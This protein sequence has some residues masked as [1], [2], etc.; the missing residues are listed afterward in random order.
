[1]DNT[2]NENDQNRRFTAKIMH[3]YR[4]GEK[5][6]K[7]LDELQRET[8]DPNGCIDLSKPDDPARS[9]HPWDILGNRLRQDGRYKDAEHLYLL[10]ISLMEKRAAGEGGGKP[11]L[12][13]LAHNDLGVVYAQQGHYFLA[14][15]EFFLAVRCDVESSGAEGLKAPAARN[16]GL[17]LDNFASAER[18]RRRRRLAALLA[19]K[20]KWARAA[21]QKPQ[22]KTGAERTSDPRKVEADTDRPASTGNATIQRILVSTL[23]VLVVFGAFLGVTATTL[24]VCGTFLVLALLVCKFELVDYIRWKTKIWELEAYSRKCFR[25][26]GKSEPEEPRCD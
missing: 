9:I 14:A 8:I 6:G 12:L 20:P 25:T 26:A 7:I 23:A 17:I 22:E 18:A 4:T 2:L 24:F 5:I 13:G 21:E 1:M 10:L 16:L 3:L 19:W 11:P 15:R